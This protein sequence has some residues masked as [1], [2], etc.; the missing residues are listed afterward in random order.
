MNNQKILIICES[1][2]HGNTMKI[3]EVMAEELTAD[4]KKPAEVKNED[5]EKYDLVGFGSGIYNGKHYISLFRFIDNLTG[6]K[7]KKCFIFS[8]ASICYEK[9]HD[10]L[11]TALLAKGFVVVGNF[12]CRGFSDY[13]FL[14]YFFGGINKNRPNQEDFSRAKEFA[15][16][17]KN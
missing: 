8:T 1:V 17:I 9:I 13:G 15:L 6:Q 14:K 16:N 2:H 10:P 7:D 3:A 11:K 12:I 4:I 5:L